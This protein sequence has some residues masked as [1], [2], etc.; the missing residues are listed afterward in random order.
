LPLL[1]TAIAYLAVA[2]AGLLAAPLHTGV[3]GSR[4][5]RGVLL[6]AVGAVYVA[7]TAASLVR[8]DT[9]W[10]AALASLLA[11]VAAAISVVRDQPA[12]EAVAGA[13]LVGVQAW[14]VGSGAGLGH[15][16]IAA[17]HLAA[18]AIWLGG[19]V[20]LAVFATR[21]PARVQLGAA[22]RRFTRYAVGSGL[23]LTGTGI[24]LLLIHHVGVAELTT[25]T[26]GAVVIGKALLLVSA[27]LLGF[28][29]R[30]AFSSAQLRRR[31]LLLRTEA[32]V[33]SGALGLAVI[34]TGLPDPQPLVELAAPGLVTIDQGNGQH[35]ALFAV[36]RTSDSALLQ[37]A[38]DE[39]L[40]VVDRSTGN[41][42]QIA[43][44]GF[45]RVAL[46]GSDALL[47]VT[48]GSRTL[49]VTIAAATP[50]ATSSGDSLTADTRSWLGYQLGQTVARAAGVTGSATAASCTADFGGRDEADATARALQGFGIRRLRVI[51][52]RS[53]RAAQLL[54][55]LHGRG[56]QLV[57]SRRTGD[58]LLAT[59][60]P[61][62][63]AALARIASSG[64]SP[65]AQPAGIYLAP[66]LLD[67]RVLNTVAT[68]RLPPLLVASPVDPMSTLADDYRQ[69][70]D[71]QAGGVAPSLAG[72]LGFA[73]AAHVEPV[74]E[75]RLYAASPV[76]FLPGVLDV[77]HQHASTGW[78][79]HGT[80]VS[81]SKAATPL[82]CRSSSSI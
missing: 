34:L 80:L 21:G 24:G 75:V 54:A 22:V 4:R 52:D 6:A 2:G 77:G 18:A 45:A 70:L 14:V 74:P 15:L 72:L 49:D 31:P 23:T 1:G 67:G 81:A 32:G 16:V 41:G 33:L 20:H 53:L 35:A 36:R 9:G 43:A 48:S 51:A 40:L 61:G 5:P 30:R 44:G 71:V 39:S 38:S 60:G 50:A 11:I 19:V 62:A 66:W 17:M 12:D 37:V 64:S 59:D 47:R 46:R 79:S 68:L 7:L 82:P 26:F 8:G 25:T 69:V 56:I 10:T 76:G 28:A 3:S 57:R 78:F 58:V 27:G 63:A 55:A 29:H 42:H 73:A 65:R 13:A